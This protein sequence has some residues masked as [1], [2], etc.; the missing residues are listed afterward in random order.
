M[1][2]ETIASKVLPMLW[3][4]KPRDHGARRPVS[5]GREVIMNM[6]Q[7]KIWSSIQSLTIFCI[8]PQSFNQ[9]FRVILAPAPTLESGKI[10]TSAEASG[11]NKMS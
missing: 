11:M 8:L 5:E 1:I 6:S 3:G 9:E 2:S 7:S 4:K 10:F